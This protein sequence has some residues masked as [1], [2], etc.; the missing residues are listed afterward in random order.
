MSYH[1]VHAQVN[2]I[3]QRT[4]TRLHSRI[5][6]ATKTTIKSQRHV[7]NL[8]CQGEGMG[9]GTVLPK[10]SQERREPGRVLY[11]HA[12]TCVRNPGRTR[13]GPG[14]ESRSTRECPIQFLHKLGALQKGTPRFT[15]VRRAI[16]ESEQEVRK[17]SNTVPYTRFCFP[18]IG[19]LG[20]NTFVKNILRLLIC[21]IMTLGNNKEY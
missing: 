12:R 4:Y 6:I 21:K 15:P 20:K 18:R 7:P 9:V 2:L 8:C 11:T 13:S 5:C 3:T 10:N 1:W 16:L 17:Q 19:I 14:R